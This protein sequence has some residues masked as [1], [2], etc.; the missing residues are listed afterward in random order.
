MVESD[1]WIMDSGCPYHMCSNR[2]WFSSIKMLDG[3]L[4]F[5]G[6]DYVH[7]IGKV[8][9]KLYDEFICTLSNIWY[10]LNLKKNLILLGILESK[11]YHVTIEGE[12]I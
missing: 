8:L 3:G 10:I 12:A 5:T 2:E 4:V 9:L 7:R 6:N 11:G 1:E